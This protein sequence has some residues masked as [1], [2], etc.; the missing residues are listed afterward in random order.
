MGRALFERS[1]P[2]RAVFDEADAALGFALSRLCFEGPDS[3]LKATANTQPAILTH[4][5]AA[6]TEL[7][8]SS[9]EKLED[10]AFAAGH[11]LGE[12]SACVAAGT[13][14][15]ADAV[16]LVRKRGEFMQDAVPAGEGAM[17]AIVGLAPEEVEAACRE[18]A[19]SEVVSAANYNS[20]EQTV[21]AG[22]ARAV[23]RAC[24]ACLA[25]GA[26]RAIPL[27]VSAP[28]H[29]VLM[30]PARQRMEPL[31]AATTFSDA[32]IPVITNVDAIPEWRGNLL[33]D[34]LVRQI[35]S[36]VRWVDGVR[37]LAREGVDRA[38]EIGPG[39]VLAGL[40][41]RIEKEIRVETWGSEA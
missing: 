27:A 8:A 36:P 22:H 39:N 11:S 21:I 24:A 38:L 40:V 18:A 7:R 35:D 23:E 30:R 31:L 3:E 37:A 15:F 29:S 9:P 41:R 28:F 6:L 2:A 26:K 32:R 33:R 16:R 10:T 17:A 34:S 25:K 12:Y 4:S 19:G 1:A 5:V 20:P 13:L 14:T